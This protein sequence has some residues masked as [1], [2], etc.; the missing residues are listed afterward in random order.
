MAEEQRR[1]SLLLENLRI[2]AEL[3]VLTMDSG[4]LPSYEVLINGA[5]S[6]DE[7]DNALR[8]E[9]WWTE[10]GSRGT[11][12]QIS[13][14][15]DYPQRKRNSTTSNMAIRTRRQSTGLPPA[16]APLS[17][18]TNVP[19][20]HHGES[21]SESDTEVHRNNFNR[22]KSSESAVFDEGDE[23]S[24]TGL[25]YRGTRGQESSSPDFDASLIP[26]RTLMHS[27]PLPMNEPGGFSPRTSSGT[28][29]MQTNDP[30]DEEQGTK[31]SIS[32]APPPSNH[33]NPHQ[34]M[35]KTS[36]NDI[37]AKAQH[38]II[39]DLIRSQSHNT[40]VLFTTL[41]P[42][43]QGTYKDEAKSEDYLEGLAILCDQTPPCILIHSKSLTVTTAL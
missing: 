13:S 28:S 7:I 5:K 24:T 1:V 29:G 42:P 41:P 35:S 10:R 4:H 33:P 21:D 14:Q 9:T 12:D 34:A 16:S 32:F 27:E 20:P 23:E 22:S 25:R 31:P 17:F 15:I 37:P 39:N 8:N 30:N 36:F 26:P 2:D 40:G 19:M 43:P 18:R 3:L 6:S 38:L 11:R